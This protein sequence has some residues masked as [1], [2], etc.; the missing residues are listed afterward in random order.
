MFKKI[1]NSRSLYIVGFFLLSL[2]LA[3]LVYATGTT[4]FIYLNGTNG[5]IGIK[6]Q[7]NNGTTSISLL[8]RTINLDTYMATGASSSPYDF[9]IPSKT[10]AEL[11]SFL[12]SARY[13][14]LVLCGATFTDSRDSNVYTTVQI[15]TQCWMAKNLA[16]LPSVVG[17]ATSSNSGRYYYVYGYE[18][19]D[20]PTA[21]ATANYST[22]GVLYNNPAALT[23]CPVGWHLPSDTEQ[24]ILDQFLNDTTC[25]A[26]RMGGGCANAGTKLKTVGPSNFNGLLAGLRQGQYGSGNFTGQGTYGSFWSSSVA[27]VDISQTW[28]RLINSS[29]AS[30]E[31]RPDRREVAYSVRCLKDDGGPNSPGT[32]ADDATV[33]TVTWTSP[34]NT[35]VADAAYASFI[36][37]GGEDTG[38][39]DNI[40]KI[41]KS[42]GSIGST[43]KAATLTNWS[44]STSPPYATYGSSSD[45]WDETWTSTDINDV[46][47]GIVLV[48]KGKGTVEISHY[49][50]A[51]NFGF[52]IPSGATINGINVEIKRRFNTTTGGGD[53]DHIRITVYYTN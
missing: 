38:Q 36:P 31:R 45:L 4:P 26:N 24:N 14:S 3:L 48:A 50:K 35:K 10:L 52:A 47:F 29:L 37:V 17:S 20:V 44:T 11:D 1:I 39:R 34:D 19:T 46:D 13:A 53:V 51:T 16:F 6:I 18:G 30:V 28:N 42:D 2:Y 21:K 15:G 27:S 33:G 25:D 7:A 8:G 41:V 43:N 9:F 22:Y 32:M 5:N 49:L 23:A 12:G 40:I